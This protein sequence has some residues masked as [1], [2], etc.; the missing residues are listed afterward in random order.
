MAIIV[1]LALLG[2][3]IR[4]GLRVYHDPDVR[5]RLKSWSKKRH[6]K[7]LAAEREATNKGTSAPV[8]RP[9]S[10]EIAELSKAPSWPDY[11]GPH[12]DG[13]SEDTGLLKAWPKGGPPELYRRPIGPGWASFAIG[14][15]RAYTIEQREDKE[16]V[17][18]SDFATGKELW[19]YDYPAMFEEERAGEGPHA[20]P[21]LDG[22]RLY[23]L[24]GSG[25]LN[26]LDAFTGNKLWGEN[27]LT[28]TDSENLEWGISG[29][30]LVVE[31]KVFVTAS[32]TEGKPSLL[33][34][35]KMTGKLL[36]KSLTQSQGYTSLMLVTMAGKR[37][38]L[39][40]AGDHLFGLDLESGEPLWEFLWETHHGIHCAQ[41]LLADEDRV[42][43][44]SAYAKGCSLVKIKPTPSGPWTAEAVWTNINMKSKFNSP[45]LRDGCIYGFDEQILT[46]LDLKTGERKWKDGRYGHGQM[47]YADGNLI[48][49]GDQGECALVKATPESYQEIS[50]FEPLHDKTWNNP[51]LAGGHLL[52][53]NGREMACFDLNDQ[54]AK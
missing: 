4:Y 26:C 37:Q 9:S 22:D 36:K 17:S 38:L 29:S 16:S 18:C 7:R 34:Y 20:T 28:E 32:G 5:Q 19:S 35:D 33:A 52:L 8:E 25:E 24:G 51:A 42:F 21:T 31:D 2:F 43:I 13:I 54:H 49:V 40:F 1:G 6:Y 50:K 48:V 44:S 15:Q 41:P 12:R 46:C 45:L 14:F 39:N 53:R 10:A 11:R 47:I 3:G 30:P 23:T 27:I